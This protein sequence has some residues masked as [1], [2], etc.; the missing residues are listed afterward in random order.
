MP[1]VRIDS[2]WHSWWIG[3]ESQRTYKRPH[4]GRE[5]NGS[6]L[7]RNQVFYGSVV[8][9]A[10]MPACHAGGHGFEPRRSRQ[11]FRAH[12]VCIWNRNKI[13]YSAVTGR[14]ALE[15]YPFPPICLFSPIGR[16]T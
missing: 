10:R 11:A 4:N 1:E 8:Q 14:G 16:D 13:K 12:G 3:L 7:S 9:S 5:Q 15:Q 2:V 6:L